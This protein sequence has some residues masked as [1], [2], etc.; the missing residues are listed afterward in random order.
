[1]NERSTNAVDDMAALH[2]SVRCRLDEQALLA[3]T[4]TEAADFL[5]RQLSSNVVDLA[6][7]RGVLSA[8]SD[9]R[10]RVLAIPRV[11]ACRDGFVLQL[12]ADRVETVRERLVKFVL[13]SDV[14][15]EVL[16]ERYGHFGVAG[17]N[18]SV[19][20]AG[21]A[22]TLPQGTADG[23]VTDSGAIVVRTE[24][25]RPRWLIHGPAAA[26]ADLWQSLDGHVRD[27]EPDQW[28][29]LDIEAGVPGVREATAG[30]FVA[31][32]L[33]LDRLGA[34]DFGKGCYPGQEVI[35]KTHYLGR[36]KRRMYLLRLGDAPLPAA[37][38]AIYAG[39]VA[40]GTCIDAAPHPEGGS[41]GL[42][43]LRTDSAEGEVKL[44][45]PD[46]PSARA[47]EPPYPLADAA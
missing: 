40:V 33:N 41:L 13:R 22:G 36:L 12:P 14:R 8:Y 43:V 39:D 15:L 34:I 16:G 37:G 32:M 2:G 29:L 11:L 30:Q 10:G 47:D 45:A 23:V 7:G 17:Q 24:G 20:L 21:A 31:Q 38:E 1:M 44:A 18:A 35:A 42:A 5:H 28:R 19:A 9:P 3:V 25:P 27:A 6:A 26:V 46:G 4:G